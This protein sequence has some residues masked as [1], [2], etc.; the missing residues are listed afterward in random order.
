MYLN[1]VVFQKILIVFFIHFRAAMNTIQQLMIILNSASD[2]P[3]DNLLFYF[4]VSSNNLT[5]FVT[6]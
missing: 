4:N 5:I 3:S 1:S 6:S 2:T